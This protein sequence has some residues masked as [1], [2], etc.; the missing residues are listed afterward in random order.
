MSRGSAVST[1][2]SLC[3][4]R[5][6]AVARRAAD[7]IIIM[8]LLRMRQLRPAQR[9]HHYHCYPESWTTSSENARRVSE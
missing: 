8:L 1:S 9:Y 6:G 7:I 4:F 3:S 5:D 2:L